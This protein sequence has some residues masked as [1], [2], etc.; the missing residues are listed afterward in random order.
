MTMTDLT[1]AGTDPG[2]FQLGYTNCFRTIATGASCRAT[3]AFSPQQKAGLLAQPGHADRHARDRLQRRLQHGDAPRHRDRADRPAAGPRRPA[4]PPGAQ[5]PPGSNTGITGPR[6]RRAPRYRRHAARAAGPVGARGA[7]GSP[8]PAGAPGAPGPKGDPG[9][10][11]PAA[12]A[13]KIRCNKSKKAKKTCKLIFPAKA[14]TA[15]ASATASYRLSRRQSV[16]AAG[17]G[18]VRRA[19]VSTF[20]LNRRTSCAAG[21]TC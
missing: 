3:V 6:A 18:T 20:Q 13:F 1:L 15:S 8:G 9:P 2:D 11:G 21:A 10:A 5:G 16:V 4:G 7:S 14:W 19:R 17:L 12:A